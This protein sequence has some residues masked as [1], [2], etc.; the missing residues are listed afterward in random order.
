MCVKKIISTFLD[1][2]VINVRDLDVQHWRLNC[3]NNSL[4][5]MC[6]NPG[7][8]GLGFAK[9]IK[10]IMYSLN[11]HFRYEEELMRNTA[12][13][14]FEAHKQ[15]HNTFFKHFLDEVRIFESGK[16]SVPGQFTW[17][18]QDWKASHYAID[19][20]MGLYLRGKA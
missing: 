16:A 19:R 5:E 12:F 3:L 4:F 17:F 13:P 7:R 6:Q 9:T 18:L 11:F 15:I 1:P 2:Y 14:D 20:E 10:Q 8:P